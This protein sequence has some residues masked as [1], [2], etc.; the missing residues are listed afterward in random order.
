MNSTT[1]TKKNQEESYRNEEIYTIDI[2]EE[3]MMVFKTVLSLEKA[4]GHSYL[5]RILKGDD[6]FGLRK[7]VHRSLET[8]GELKEMSY[9][10]IE[11][12]ILY[13][14]KTAYLQTRDLR[15]GTLV[16]SDKAIAFMKGNEP[17]KVDS[18]ELRANWY[19]V[20]LQI[21]LKAIRKEFSTISGIPVSRIFS[22]FTL[23][24]LIEKRPLSI[25]EIRKLPGC[26][27]FSEDQ[28]KVIADLMKN[29]Q[30]K[31]ERDNIDGTFRKVYSPVHRKI[32]S[33]H[34]E[35]KSITEIIAEI[36]EEMDIKPST[37]REFFAN[38]HRA[39]ELDLSTW[40]EEQMGAQE[41]HRGMEYFKQAESPLLTEAK[42]VLGM[43]Y[44]KLHMCRAYVTRVEEDL[45]TYA[46]AS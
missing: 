16:I 15:Y 25:G 13:L 41:L 14:V 35:G 30:Q 18:R 4:Y 28:A 40:I 11:K 19:D 24:Q 26:K 29:M 27:H 7:D 31:I 17:M 45:A 3:A 38:L 39:G 8:F 12:L 10:R 43:D 9:T 36:S 5:I 21:Q 42:E 1:N 22:N 20:Q 44:D 32:K 46:I 33:M 6:R 34:Q 37:V 2:R 23:Q